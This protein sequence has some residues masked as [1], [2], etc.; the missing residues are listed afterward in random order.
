MSQPAMSQSAA[1][2][3]PVRQDTAVW[4]D[5]SRPAA[6]RAGDLLGRMT[7]EE[8]VAQLTSVWLG[9]P[10]DSNV[11]PMQGDFREPQAPLAELISDGLGQLTRVFGTRPVPP[12][13]AAR[14]LA[15]LQGQIV[16]ASRF[17]IPAVA[18]EECLTGFAAWTATVFPAPLAWGASFDPGLVHEM[19]AAIGASMRAAGIHQGLA[20]VL[21]VTRDLR[22]GPVEETIGEDPY[23]VGSVGTAYVQGLQSA[24]VQATLKH[25]AGYS[26]S[27]AGRNMAPVAI[28]A[29]EFADVLLV[30]F[31]MALRLGGARSVMPS[32]TDVDG[33]PVSADRS[34]LTGLLRDELGFD[35]VVVSDY[36]A[37]AFLQTQ[38]AVAATPAQAAA[39]A[40]EA[41]VDVE[42][43]A[44]AC[45]GPALV[46]AVR[47][48]QIPAGLVDRAAARELR[49]K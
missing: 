9:Q 16:A 25:F 15:E 23:L 5:P 8:K 13:E 44:A 4:R 22:W 14:T 37:I 42:L 20:P 46:S 48:G 27:R 3:D 19:A 30:P 39:L 47:E 10:R 43:P 34:L 41:G 40:L 6:E 31:E 36:Y 17:G 21:D 35:G 38:H 2:Q 7:L 28:G 1:S 12:A 45:Y 11:A 18:H 24:G 33:V 49:Q 29:R 32:Y 26:A